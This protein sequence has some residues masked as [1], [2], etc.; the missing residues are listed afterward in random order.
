MVLLGILDVEGV[1]VME[2]GG[3]SSVKEVGTPALLVTVIKTLPPAIAVPVQVTG[4]MPV[5]GVQLQPGY[6]F[7]GELPIKTVI[8]EFDDAFVNVILLMD[9]EVML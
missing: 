2:V 3:I 9:A 6:Q 5:P 7:V 4:G 1:S 8:C